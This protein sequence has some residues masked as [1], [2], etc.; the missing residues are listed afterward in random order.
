MTRP[1]A[2]L[3]LGAPRLFRI[4]VPD[5]MTKWSMATVAGRPRTT[6]RDGSVLAGRPPRGSATP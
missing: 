6:R 4:T 1:H 5:V 2:A 3:L